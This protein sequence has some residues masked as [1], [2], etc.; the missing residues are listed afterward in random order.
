MKKLIEDAR[1]EHEEGR[2]EVFPKEESRWK[3]FT[4]ALGSLA[5]FLRGKPPHFF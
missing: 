5:P 1:K 4:D 3:A 2:S